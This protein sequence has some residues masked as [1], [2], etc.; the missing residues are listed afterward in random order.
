MRKLF[1]FFVVINSGHALALTCGQ[2]MNTAPRLLT[3]PLTW[4]FFANQT[5]RHELADGSAELDEAV[6]YLNYMREIQDQVRAR[7]ADLPGLKESVKIFDR[8]G[9]QIP[10]PDSPI[11]Q[12]FE[13]FLNRS[14]DLP[15]AFASESYWASIFVKGGLLPTYFNYGLQATKESGPIDERL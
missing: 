4:E 13:K 11:H 9:H 1:I 14:N 7:E 8:Y 12:A 6:Q 5:A 15:Q 2:L 10:L 3:A